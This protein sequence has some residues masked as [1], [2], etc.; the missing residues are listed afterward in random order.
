MNLRFSTSASISCNLQN[1]KAS[2]VLV[3]RF[4]SSVVGRY[5]NASDILTHEEE[6]ACARMLSRQDEYGRCWRARERRT[7]MASDLPTQLDRDFVECAGLDRLVLTA[8]ARLP[9]SE[10]TGCWPKG[11]KF[12]L[13]LSHDIDHVTSYAAREH[14]RSI[15]RSL[16]PGQWGQAAV[17]RRAA[18]AL[19]ASAGTLMRRDLL[20]R[21]D[22]IGNF[23]DWLRIENDLGFKS[24]LYFFAEQVM[25]WH[26]FDCNYVFSDTVFFDGRRTT[27][28]EMMREIAACGWEISVHGS[29]SSATEPGVLAYQKSQIEAV[30]EQQLLTTRQHYLQYDVKITPSIQSA[31]GFRA[32]GTHG[33]NDILGARAGTMFPYPMWDGNLGRILPLFEFPLHIQDGPLMRGTHGVDDAVEACLAWIDRAA[34]V[35]GCLGLL[36]HPLWLATD[37]GIAVYKAVLQEAKRRNAWGCSMRE[38]LLWWENR[39]KSIGCV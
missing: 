8:R 13:C 2:N 31:A 10:H 19:K 34:T 28:R 5:V 18:I 9:K 32:D 7:W 30:I 38:A 37:R 21:P 16:Q 14:W 36:F 20:K 27:V 3:S 17:L 29:F 26:H 23:S 12:A 15:A 4:L 25:P 1:H 6:Q 33:F 22:R 35:G 39:A 11:H 24:S